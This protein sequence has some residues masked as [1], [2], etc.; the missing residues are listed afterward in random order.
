MLR[1]FFPGF[2]IVGVSFQCLSRSW[3]AL[4]GSLKR[5]RDGLAVQFETY[6][7]KPEFPHRSGGSKFMTKTGA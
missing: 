1:F 4:P 2:R 5:H 6:N 7:P 3:C